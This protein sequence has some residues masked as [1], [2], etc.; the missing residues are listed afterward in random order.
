[1]DYGTLRVT[2]P[3]GQVREYPIDVPSA[4]VGRAEGNRVVIDHVTVSR[5]HA[6]LTIDSGRL[7]VED[8]G[9]ATGTFVGS[10][11]VAPHSPSLVAEGLTIR[12]GDV[13]ALFLGPAPATVGPEVPL[14]GAMPSGAATPGTPGGAQPISV[15]V[16]SP[17][18]PVAAGSPTTATVVLQNRGTV[19]DE[20]SLSVP[21][22]PAGWVR[23]S[24]TNLPL[25]PGARDEVTIVIQPPHA[26]EALA[27]EYSFA[28]AV[29]SRELGIEVR[30]LG[31]LTVLPFDG[32]Q[33]ALNPVR[34]KRDF[35]VT[36][37]NTGNAPA[38][39]TLTGADDEGRLRYRFE[40]DHVELQPG[41]ERSIAVRVRTKA[42]RWFGKEEVKPFHVEARPAT[43]GLQRHTADGQLR[44]RATL[45]AWK[46]LIVLLLLGGVL[47][48]GA[49][50]YTRGCQDGWPFC[51]ESKAVSP[52]QPATTTPPP[53]TQPPGGPTSVASPTPTTR[54][55][56]PSPGLKAG[57]TAVVTNSPPGGTGNTNCLAVRSKPEINRANPNEGI[58]R[59]LCDGAEVTV[60]AGPT[61]DGT[62]LFWRVRDSAGEGWA[63]EGPVTGNVRWLVP[64]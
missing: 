46:W 38:A 5:R 13:E 6:R 47:G 57:S 62:Y 12:F 31:R 27:G 21:D 60:V 53:V 26:P 7:M 35:K 36:T 25:L 16:K 29:V 22:L 30:A 24:R 39:Y 4:F 23:I 48:G 32:F 28:V 43:A 56:T 45:Q 33:M 10:Q 37:Q 58:L 55:A 9:S 54:P 8:L 18:A 19:V 42:R 44:S 51:G 17:T 59:R 40:P 50:G 3:D 41:E 2:T 64:K 1:M 11:R 49:W 20:F 14:A 61:N 63:A 15:S 34:A 52:S